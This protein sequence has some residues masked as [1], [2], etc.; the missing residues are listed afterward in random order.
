MDGH[1]KSPHRDEGNFEYKGLLCFFFLPYIG[2][3]CID[4]HPS[5]CRRQD[6]RADR[7]PFGQSQIPFIFDDDLRGV[8]IAVHRQ[9][10]GDAISDVLHRG[11]DGMDHDRIV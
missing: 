5:A 7:D 9:G 6:A 3:D 11:L 2:D 4:Q 8:S 1:Q 10:M